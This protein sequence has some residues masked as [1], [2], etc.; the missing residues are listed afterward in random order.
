MTAT[1]GV[2]TIITVITAY[3]CTMDRDIITVTRAITGDR[4]III[5]L[6]RVCTTGPTTIRGGAFI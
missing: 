4:C 5:H 1:T 3:A 6:T 2:I